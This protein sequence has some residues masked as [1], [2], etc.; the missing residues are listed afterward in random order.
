[1][2]EILNGAKKALTKGREQV[3]RKFGFDKFSEDFVEGIREV[4]GYSVQKD[5]SKTKAKRQEK[6]E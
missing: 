5:K 6:R 1:M 2:Y 4:T 3:I